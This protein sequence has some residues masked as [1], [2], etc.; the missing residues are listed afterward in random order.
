MEILGRIERRYRL[1]TGYF[2]AELPHQA[3]A[4]IGPKRAGISLAE[5]RRL[6]GHLPDD[7]DRRPKA[8]RNVILEWVRSV[9]ISGST[10]YRRFQAVAMKQRY[11]IR[12]PALGHRRGIQSAPDCGETGNVGSDP[13]PETGT[14]IAPY[15]LA[16]EM[17]ALVS[18]KTSTL[19]LIG[20]QRNGV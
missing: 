16:Q 4:T 6:A 2:K 19:A 15:R 14:L 12:F 13:E 18:C 11:A 5:Q 7:F 1:P 20:Y 8:E 10:D 3:R 9:I 17:D